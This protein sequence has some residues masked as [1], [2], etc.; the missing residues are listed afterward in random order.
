MAAFAAHAGRPLL[1]TTTWRTTMDGLP[2]LPIA[3][4]TRPPLSVPLLAS[5]WPYRH[6]CL[7][8]L[9]VQSKRGEEGVVTSYTSALPAP[10]YASGTPTK[11]TASSA[12]STVL[13]NVQTFETSSA[14]SR[15]VSVAANDHVMPLLAYTFTDPLVESQ[16]VE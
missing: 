2:K 14:K 15:A 12:T 7:D 3:A 11:S 1:P 9:H 5:D 10:P 16:L 8:P 13:P 4:S 6:W